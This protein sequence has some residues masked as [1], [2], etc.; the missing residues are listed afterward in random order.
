MMPHLIGKSQDI[1]HIR[2]IVHHTAGL[3]FHTIISGESGVGKEVVAQSL[4][5]NSPRRGNPIVKVNCAALPDS[6]LDSE[7]FG[8][9]KGAFTGAVKRQRGKLE[10][11]HGG[12]LFLDEIGEM[13]HKLQARLLHVLE[14]GK[15][16]PLGSEEEI[17]TDTWLITATNSC[18]EE[19]VKSGTFRE[20]LYYRLNIIR[21]PIRPLRERPEDIP[22]LIDYYLG[23]YLSGGK[24]RDSRSPNQKTLK[25]L[26]AYHWPGNVRELQSVI[27]RFALIGNWDV[28]AGELPR[29]PE[30]KPDM[31]YVLPS[32]IVPIVDEVLNVCYAASLASDTFSLK[33]ITN[34]ALAKIER[35]VIRHT[36]LKTGW[37]RRRASKLLDIAYYTLNRKIS[38][39]TITPPRYL[40]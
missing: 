28:V 11:A 2:D 23:L 29:R 6:L 13:S 27:R 14:G 21:I 8:H 38:D 35:E 31:T 12:V 26:A 40:L 22:P 19:K 39:L 1:E 10:M 25:K 5:Q 30:Q 24:K 18:L 36:L 9:E 7:L 37:N 4:H 17:R 20:D 3:G 34:E 16:S 32:F 15:F 33:D